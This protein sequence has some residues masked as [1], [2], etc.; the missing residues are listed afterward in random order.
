MLRWLLRR[1][2]FVL[3]HCL[4]G[5]GRRRFTNA[6]NACGRITRRSFLQARVSREMIILMNMVTSHVTSAIESVVLRPTLFSNRRLIRYSQGIRSRHIRLIVFSILFRF[7]HY[8]P[9]FI[10]RNRLRFIPMGLYF[11]ESRSEESFQR[12]SLSS[13]T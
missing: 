6:Q 10:Q 4:T 13:A 11:D 8:R 7:F 3:F 9:T 1:V 12:F 2:R 5:R